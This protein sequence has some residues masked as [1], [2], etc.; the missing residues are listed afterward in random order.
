MEINGLP[1]HPLLVHVVVVLLP[2]A[3]VGGI[4]VSLW[5]AAQRK[6]TFLVPL[7]A[8][9]GTA[10]VPLTTEAGESLEKKLGQTTDA[11][12]KHASYGDKVIWFAVVFAVASVVQWWL[13]RGEGP[14][15]VVRWVVAAVV[16]ASAVGV[17]TIVFLTGDTGA[18][19]VWG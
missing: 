8:V 6:L 12:E 7:A 5:P 1:A 11:I 10:V 4:L 18:R 17:L 14:S 3:A 16:V 15:A 9:V 13:L 19:A 2:L